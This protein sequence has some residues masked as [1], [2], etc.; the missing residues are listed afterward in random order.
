VITKTTPQ[1]WQRYAALPQE[2]RRVADKA[3]VLWIDDPAHGSLHF[4]KLAGHVAL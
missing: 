3:C 4:K 1:F 2:I